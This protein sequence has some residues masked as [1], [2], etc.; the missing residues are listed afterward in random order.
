MITYNNHPNGRRVHRSTE[1]KR[2]ALVAPFVVV[3][4]VV[5]LGCAAL[6]VDVGMMYRARNDAQ[7]VADAAALAAASQLMDPDRLSGGSDMT[8]QF[9]AARAQAAAIAADNYVLNTV[10]SLNLESDVRFCYLNDPTD[11]HETL[12]YGN[13]SYANSVE[14]TVRRDENVNGPIQLYFAGIFGRTRTDIS[15]RAVATL[16][17]GVTGFTAPSDGS[18]SSLIPFAL[19]VDIWQELI[20]GTLSHGD[21]YGY[22]VTSKTVSP[23]GDGINEINM[24]PNGSGADQ[25]PPGNFGTVDIGNSSNSTSILER[26]IADGVSAED[27]APYGGELN[28]GSDGTLTLTGDTGLSGG[29]ED[30]LI[31]VIG[32]VRTIPLFDTVVN[33]G[34]TAEFTIVGFA[35]IRIMD[36]D[37]H[38]NPNTMHVLIQPAYVVDPSAITGPG[39]GNSSF[40]YQP[41]ILSR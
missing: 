28:L 14:V 30:T 20:S 34:N 41:V 23:V 15:A 4:L 27:L 1:N 32:E 21:S 22:D 37:L 5:L 8:Q 12:K 29:M 36:V 6:S 7:C 33:P 9:A 10:P 13:F 39:S 3:M 11:P 26:Q 17:N 18:G 16:K 40:V 24:Y 2:P 35:G 38:T 31:S 25:L 19:N